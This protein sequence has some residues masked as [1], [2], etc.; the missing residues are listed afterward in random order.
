MKFGASYAIKLRNVILLKLA[1]EFLSEREMYLL[2]K[3]PW[4]FGE[5]KRA[6]EGLGVWAERFWDKGRDLAGTSSVEPG[7]EERVEPMGRRSA[8]SP[9]LSFSTLKWPNSQ[10]IWC[11]PFVLLMLESEG[12]ARVSISWVAAGEM[13][14]PEWR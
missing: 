5:Q 9:Q 10:N 3:I 1:P 11:R 6:P 8:R 4:E 13:G 12:R 14:V 7:E 2:W